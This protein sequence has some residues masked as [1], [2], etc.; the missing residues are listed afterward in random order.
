MKN[1]IELT[2]VGNLVKANKWVLGSMG[3]ATILGLLWANEK[4][5]VAPQ[6]EAKVQGLTQQVSNFREAVRIL[7]DDTCRLSVGNTI[8]AKNKDNLYGRDWI[9]RGH[10]PNDFD[11]KDA[12]RDGGAMRH[13]LMKT[14]CSAQ[15]TDHERLTLTWDISTDEIVEGPKLGQ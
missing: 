14:W 4:F 1:N 10:N 2:E 3:V 7:R 6:Q 15:S 9:P 13:E 5:F 11:P 8:K 12:N